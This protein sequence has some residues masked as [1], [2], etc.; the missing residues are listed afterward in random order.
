MTP[1]ATAVVPPELEALLHACKESPDEAAPRLVLADWLE[2]HGQAAL[3]G[4]VRLSLRHAEL[5]RGDPRRPG[6]EADLDDPAGE[7]GRWLRPLRAL[8]PTTC[9]RGGL[10]QV[11]TTVG[12]LR[13]HSPGE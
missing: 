8:F 4:A 2:E 3:A 9:F 5:G 7:V 13:G 12:V 6:I 10:L 1:S 11:S